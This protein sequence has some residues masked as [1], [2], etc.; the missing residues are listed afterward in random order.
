VQGYSIYKAIDG[1][2]SLAND[3]SFSE[4]WLL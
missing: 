3:S 1:Y 4:S 2:L